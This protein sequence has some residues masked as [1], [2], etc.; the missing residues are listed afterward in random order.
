MEKVYW[1]CDDGSRDEDQ[2][3]EA[4]ALSDDACSAECSLHRPSLCLS[5]SL[6]L[7]HSIPPPCSSPSPSPLSPFL[8]PPPSPSSS[9]VA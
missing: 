8:S 1:Q 9:P 2:K 6:S 4:E 7:S 3:M 5:L